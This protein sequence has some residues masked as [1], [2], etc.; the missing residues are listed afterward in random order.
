MV[1][2][3]VWYKPEGVDRYGKTL[4]SLAPDQEIGF[5]FQ[6]SFNW[7][8][9]YDGKEIKI[10]QQSVHIDPQPQDIDFKGIPV[11]DSKNEVL[12]KISDFLDDLLR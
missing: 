10:P 11:V 12:K 2:I 3:Q 7:V 4:I 6:G 9:R 8:A 1:Q 5:G